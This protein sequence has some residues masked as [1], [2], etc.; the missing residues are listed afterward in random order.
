MRFTLTLA[1]AAIAATTAK[2]DIPLKFLGWKPK[3]IL[4]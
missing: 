3:Q 2:A 1:L 4:K